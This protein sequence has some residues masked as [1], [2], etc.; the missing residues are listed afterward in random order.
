MVLHPAH[1][2]MGR[3]EQVRVQVFVGFFRIGQ[4]VLGPVLEA[5]DVVE[6]MVADAVSPFHYPPEFL[7]ML[8]HVVAHHEEGSLDAVMVQQVQYPGSDP[9]Y[10]TIVECQVHRFLLR[11]HAPQGPWVE[12]SE[13]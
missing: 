2:A 5:T 3:P 6:R 13:Q 1:V 11:I 8:P 7:R 12:P 4:V 10:W 9:G